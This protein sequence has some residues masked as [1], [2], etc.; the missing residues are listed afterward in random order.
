[1]EMG[2]IQ[3]NHD[4]VYSSWRHGVLKNAKQKIGNKE[5]LP[6]MKEIITEGLENF[7]KKEQSLLN[8]FIKIIKLNAKARMEATKAKT[9]TQTERLNTFKEH[10]HI[11]LYKPL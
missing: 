10:R 11:V 1:M 5:L 3:E 6:Y 4:I 8:D 9:A 2:R 7:F